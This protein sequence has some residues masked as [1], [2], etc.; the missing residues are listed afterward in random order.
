MVPLD[1]V[2]A[3]NA[4]LRELGPGLVALFV[5]GTSG[6]GEFTLKAFVSNTVSPRVY[7]VGRSLPA[8]ERIIAECKT[9][10]EGGEVEFLKADV[11]E[12]AEVDRVCGEIKR[13]EGKE[14]KEG[15]INLLVQTQ[16]NLTLAGRQESPE[17]LD[18]KATLNFYSR[19]RFIH[20]LLPLLHS[21]T[22]SP[23]HFSRT[24]SV[25]GAGHESLINLNDLELKNGYSGAKN[26]AHTTVMNDF[27]M[28][29]WA[30]R[31]PGTTF[32]HTSP[33][34][35]VM[36]GM[37]RE[38]PSWARVGMKIFTPLFKP[39]AV[40]PEETGQRHL[41]IATSGIFPPAKPA[42]GAKLASGVPPA[43]GVEIAQGEDGKTGSGGYLVNWDCEVTGKNQIL[44]DYREKGVS[45]TVWEHT[46]GVFER[47]EKINRERAVKGGS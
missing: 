27:M 11:S 36:T 19:M 3:S 40:S 30:S 13:R 32:V 15:R 16:G 33:G 8:A 43:K 21:S 22:T 25:L 17:G 4:Q 7:I 42:E 14:G 31:E 18:R 29:E 20:N 44:K 5:G 41:F 1:V 23:P 9:L 24:L 10:N 45:K 35:V 37:A 34:I 47:V 38:L 28:G 6:I 39:F 12:L 26:A 2:K 46:M